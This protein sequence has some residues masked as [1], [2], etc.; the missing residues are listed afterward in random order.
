MFLTV[1]EVADRLRL[2]EKTVRIMACRGEL[3]AIRLAGP[4]SALRF[5]V[6]AI[7]E[8]EATRLPASA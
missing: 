8:W 1:A 3:R 7:A 2:H 4:R 5:P 6:A